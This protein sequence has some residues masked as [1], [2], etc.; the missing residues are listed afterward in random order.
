[1]KRLNYRLLGRHISS[2]TAFGGVFA[3]LAKHAYLSEESRTRMIESIASDG[4]HYADEHDRVSRRSIGQMAELKGGGST[5]NL[6]KQAVK[7]IQVG[8][9]IKMRALRYLLMGTALLTI[10]VMPTGSPAEVCLEGGTVTPAKG[11]IF[12]NVTN[13]GKTFGVVALKLDGEKIKCAII[14]DPLPPEAGFSLR[15]I[16]TLVCEDHSQ[17]SFL[18][19]GNPTAIVQ[20]CFPNFD[21]FSFQEVSTPD[22]TRPIKGLF[23]GMTGGSLTIRG[24][25]NCEFELDMKF[26]GHLCLP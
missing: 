13:D 16:H 22:L 10:L 25:I 17:A 4:D 7:T 21:A 8:G 26:E 11:K 5:L 1:V 3:A 15:F 20:A 23:E 2:P 18:T 24:I 9:E 14:G 12:N 6:W 19:Q